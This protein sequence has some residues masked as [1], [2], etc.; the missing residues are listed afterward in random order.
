MTFQLEV[1]SKTEDVVQTL[2]QVRSSSSRKKVEKLTNLL[3]DSN[4]VLFYVNLN[5]STG[6]PVWKSLEIRLQW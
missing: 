3:D 1:W 4:M 6:P 2:L 5:S